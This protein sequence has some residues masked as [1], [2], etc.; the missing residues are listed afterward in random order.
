MSCCSTCLFLG[1]RKEYTENNGFL[2]I[3]KIEIN[4][5]V[6]GR[7]IDYSKPQLVYRKFKRMGT[8][9]HTS[10]SMCFF[11]RLRY[12]TVSVTKKVLIVLLCTLKVNVFHLSGKKLQEDL[13]LIDRLLSTTPAAPTDECYK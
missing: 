1:Q 4:N 11:V 13:F 9:R 2:F 6:S 12:I 10:S 3:F 7:N 8:L 5:K